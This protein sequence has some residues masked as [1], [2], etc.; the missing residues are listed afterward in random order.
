MKY[1]ACEGPEPLNENPP[2]APLYSISGML[3][4]RLLIRAITLLVCAMEEPGFVFMLTITVPV[5]SCGISPVFVTLTS[6]TSNPNEAAIVPH[7]SH[8]RWMIYSTPRT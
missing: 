4:R 8:R 5:S 1:M 3:S 2:T 6:K 7:N